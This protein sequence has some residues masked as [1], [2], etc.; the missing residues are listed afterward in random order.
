VLTD[1]QGMPL[2]AL[3]TGAHRHAVTQLLPL[4]AAIPPVRGKQGRPQHRPHRVH[5]DRGDDSAP[6]RQALRAMGITPVLGKRRM[7][8]GSGLGAYRWVVERTLAWLPQ[9]RRL[10]IRYERRADIP[11]AFLTLGCVLICWRYLL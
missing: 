1:A 3:M 7:D 6:H 4:L 9:W 2:A 11:E 10:R 5:G 8:H